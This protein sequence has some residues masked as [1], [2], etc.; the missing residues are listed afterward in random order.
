MDDKEHKIISEISRNSSASQR[1]LS[2]VSDLSLGMV[3]IILHRLIEKG[4]MKIKQLDGRKVNYILT[5][6]GFS[7]KIERSKQYLK[8]TIFNVSLIKNSLKNAVLEQY[9]NGH[10]Q[11]VILE[12]REL[13]HM[14]EQAV[15]ESGL[16][17]VKFLFKET[18][19]IIDG[20]GFVIFY[21]ESDGAKMKDNGNIY[22]DVNK[23]LQDLIL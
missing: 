15:K 10:K 11:F 8:K 1:D 6:K 22:V 9:Q 4:Y 23:V 3:N 16:S 21:M 20:T 19:D 17:D 14:M 18:R 5:P 12:S 13:L 7:E 2:R